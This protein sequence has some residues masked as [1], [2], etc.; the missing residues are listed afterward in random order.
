MFVMENNIE[1]MVIRKTLEDDED[2]GM[3]SSLLDF[4]FASKS[5][6]LGLYGC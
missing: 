2:E 6:Q 5:S 3:A 4:Y 1:K